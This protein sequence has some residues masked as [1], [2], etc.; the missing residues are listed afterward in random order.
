MMMSL[1][2]M[3]TAQDPIQMQGVIMP[4]ASCWVGQA[5]SV[6]EFDSVTALNERSIVQEVLCE[7]KSGLRNRFI[8]YWQEVL[9]RCSWP[10]QQRLVGFLFLSFFVLYFIV[11]NLNTIL[12]NVVFTL[13]LSIYWLITVKNKDTI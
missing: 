13:G 5:E 12:I 8:C 10:D 7:M 2:A 4:K 1:A 9:I 6:A 3:V 11:F